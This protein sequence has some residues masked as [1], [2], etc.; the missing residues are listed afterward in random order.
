[1][2]SSALIKRYIEE[3]GSEEVNSFLEE[4]DDVIISPVTLIE[5]ISALKRRYSEGSINKSD[6]DYLKKTVESESKDFSKIIFDMSLE[7]KAVNLI[8]K[9]Q[10]RALDS[11]QL[12]SMLISKS[13]LMVTSDKKLAGCSES[14]HIETKL[15]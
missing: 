10:L 9:Y 14:E 5:M 2:D 4:A 12:A 3:P 13:H 8:N 1:M 7:N 11:I 15:I 6:Y